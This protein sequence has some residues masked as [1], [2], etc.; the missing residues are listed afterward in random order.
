MSFDEGYKA[1]TVG[2]AKAIETAETLGSIREQ[3]RIIAIIEPFAKC[4][5]CDA[6]GKADD[7]SPAL[8]QYIIDLIKKVDK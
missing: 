2:M 3:K 4:D 6:G 1:G 5:E 8:A 7:C